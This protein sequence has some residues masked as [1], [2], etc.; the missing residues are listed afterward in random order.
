MGEQDWEGDV[1]FATS[2]EFGPYVRDGQVQI[3]S[4]LIGQCRD[5]RGEHA[6]ANRIR[7]DDGASFPHALALKVGV[8]TP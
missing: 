6:F 7:I 3:E 5:Q 8:S 1:F 2:G 4:P